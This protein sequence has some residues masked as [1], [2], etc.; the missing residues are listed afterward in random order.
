MADI[1][2]SAAPIAA[3]ADESAIRHRLAGRMPR[4]EPVPV[5]S[6][7]SSLPKWLRRARAAASTADSRNAVAAEWLLDNDYHVQRAILQI[8]EDLPPSFYQRLPGIAGEQARGAPRVY[9]LAHAL[10]RASHLQIALGSAVE[11]I[12]HYQDEEPL[13]IAELWA[14]PTMLR[15]ACLE[16]LIAGFARLFKDVPPPFD[17]H[18]EGQLSAGADDTECV[19][20]AIAN[21]A[22]ISSIPWKMFFDR[23]SRV[24]AILRRDPAA[25]YARMDFD[26][27]DRY[28]HAVEQLA[29]H[30]G[31]AEWDVAERLLSQ[32]HTQGDLPT[33]HIGYWL[34]DAGRPAFEDALHARPLTFVSLG[35]WLARYP[36]ALYTAALILVG[37]AGFVLPAAYLLTVEAKLSS[38]LIGIALIT[39]PASVLSVTFVNWLVT[40]LVAPRVLP[41][42]DFERGIAADCRTAVVMPV[43]VGNVA[44]IAPVLQRI[45]SHRLANSDPSLRFVLL[46]DHA[47]ADAEAMPGDGAIERALVEGIDRLNRRYPGPDG[48][49]PFHLLHRPRLYNAA[50]G[51]WMG[52]ERK[53]GKL[54]Q[55]NALI[56]HGTSTPFSVTTGDTGRLAGLR[57]VVTADADTR[58][59][60]GVV[61]QMVAAL[62]HPLN[63]AHF[64]PSSGR[65][66]SGYTILQ[67]RVEIAPENSGRS[68]FTHFFGGDTAI[69]I[70][71]RAVSDVYQDIF[72]TGIFVGKGIYDVAAFE[73][74]LAGRIPENALLSH[75][76]FE[77]LHGR[78][79][80]ASDII[81]YEG[82]PAGYLDYS[83]RWH[84]W[85]R[86]DWQIVAWLFP[87]VP[88]ADGSRVRNRLT[89]F[90]RL[91]IFDNLR[92]SVV[93]PSLVALLIGGW[94]LLGGNP[95]VWTLLALA[96]PAAYLF[97]DLVTG[98][99]QGRRRGVLQGVLRRL[100][101]HAGRWA[102]AITFL[103]SDSAIA[104]SAIVTTVTRLATR[105]RLLE[106]T[107]AAQM[108]AHVATLHPRWA[109]WRAML[110]SPLF[111]IAVAVALA[112]IEPKVL[113]IAGPILLLWLLAPEIAIWITRP[114][115]RSVE[116][117]DDEDRL[118]LRRL[119][120]RTWL[121]FET[122]VRP[123][124]NWLPPDNYQAPP[125][126]AT[127]HRTSPTNVGMMMLSTLT[128]WKLGHI[129]ANE[130]AVRLRNVLDTLDRL[131]RYRGHML[132]WY[133]TRTGQALE[134]R[135]VSA[136]DSGNLA[137]SLV[138]AKSACRE[139]ARAPILSLQRWD[140]LVDVLDLLAE[141]LGVEGI[142]GDGACRKLVAAMRESATTAPGQPAAW[143]QRL[144]TL[145][146]RDCGQLQDQVHHIIAMG[147][148]L[149]TEALHEVQVWVERAD[150]HLRAMQRDVDTLLPWQPFLEAP[151][152]GCFEIADELRP[153]LVDALSA[154]SEATALRA[155][156]TIAAFEQ[157]QGEGDTRDWARELGAALDLG[158]AAS[159]AL[160][161]DLERLASDAARQA[162]AMDFA[163]LFDSTT[164]L[165]NIGY[166]VSADRIDPHHYDLLASEARLASFFAIS[167]GD[168]PAEHW[169]SLGRPITKQA[170]G[171]ALV[172]WNGSMFEY[173]MPNLF[174]RSDPETL[175]GQ[176]D[177][178]AV[179]LQRDY[180]AA[181]NIP[182][183]ISESSFASMGAD[184]VY[185]YHAF[186]VPALGLRRGL[187]RDL[188]VAPYATA[189]ALAARPGLAIRNM[190][191]LAALGLIGRYGFYEAV[192]F[193]PERVPAGDRFAIVRSYMAHHQGMALAAMGN[194]LCGDMFVD[195]FHADPHIRT[196]DLLLNERI[197][198]ELP[199]EISR[200][201]TREAAPVPEGAIPPLHSW[202]AES[203]GRT[204]AVHVIGNGRMASR[205]TEG[206]S[207]SLHWH[208][209][210]LTRSDA[211]PSGSGISIYLRER[212]S[213]ALWSA[214]PEPIRSGATDVH[215]RFHGHQVEYHRRDHG[216][217]T[218]MTVSIPHGDDVEIRRIMVVNETD[219][220]RTIDFTSYAEVVL[221]P[222]ADAARHPA[223]SKLFVGS[224]MLPA[225]DG[226]LFSRRARDPKESTPVLLH[227]AIADEPGL[228]VRGVETDR[229]AFLG[230]HGHE[231]APAAL[232]GDTLPGGLGWTLDPVI[233]LQAEIEIPPFGR[234]EIAFLTI[235]A[236]SRETV[237][238]IAERY[239]TIPSMDWAVSDAATAVAR[240]MH[241]LGLAPHRVP[242]AQKLLS[243]LLQPVSPRATYEG[244]GSG[245]A[246][247]Q[248][249]WAL[250]ISGDHPILLLGAGDAER[251]GL[252]RFLLSAHQLWRHRGVAVDLVV[253]HEGAEGYLE[254]VRERLLAVLRDAGVQ[255]QLGQN[256]G[257]H[258]VGIERA[259]GDR[260]RL[261]GRSA[262]LR[263]DERGGSIADQ[264]S[265]LDAEPLSGPRFTPVVPDGPVEVPAP[266]ASPPRESL[267]FDNGLG[268]FTDG[269]R[270]Y[271]VAL[272][273]GVQTPAPWSN[274]LAN[275]GFGTIVTEAGLGFSWATNSGENRI[276]PWH[277]DPVKDPQGEILYVRDEENARVWTTTPQPAGGDSAARVRH[278]AGYTIWERESEGLAQE[279][280][281]AV[282]NDDP[283]KL[284]RLCLRNL[285]PRTRRITA[286]YYAEWLLGAVRGES[287][288]LRAADYDAGAHVLLATN[289]WNEE[290]Q[291]RT[292]FLTSTVPPH[293]LTTSRSDFLGRDGDVRRPQGLDKWDLGGRQQAAGGDCCAALQV[294]LDI[295]PGE[296]AEVCF[297]LGQ[298][299][300]RA[301]A[302]ALAQSWQDPAAID[303]GM[304]QVRDAWETRLGAVCVTTPDPAFDIMVNRWLPY[305]VTSARVRARAGFY[306]AGGAFGYRDQLQDVLALLHSDP[307]A[308][309]AQILAAAAHQ[310]EEGDVLHWWHPPFDRGVRTRCSDDMLWLT[311]ATATYVEATGDRAILDEE[312][313]FLRGP[314]LSEGESDRYA[315]FDVTD[316]PV[317]LFEHCERALDR[318][319]RL[320]AHGLPLMGAGDWNDGMNRVG[321]H[322]RGESVWLGWFLITAIDG[323]VRLCGGRGRTDLADR[324]TQRAR[325]LGEAVERSGWDGDWYLRA[326]DDDGRP[327]GSHNDEECRIDAI[328]QSWAVLSGAGDKARATRAVAAAR[329]ELV[330]DD[331]SIVRLLT[332]PFDRTPR[333]PGYIKAYPPG[334]RENGGQYTHAAAWLG[335]ATARLGDG[336][337]SMALFERINPINHGRSPAE[338]AQYRTEPYVLAGDVAGSAPH[339]GRGGW[340]WYTGAAGWVWRW[341]VE[342]ILG[343]RLVEGGIAI[344]CCLPPTWPH[345]EARITRASGSLQI[346]VDNPAGLATGVG[347]IKVDGAP[348]DQPIIPFPEDG[349]TRIVHVE[350]VPPAGT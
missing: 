289:P 201:E 35:R 12:E 211:S 40:L 159:A 266:G 247:R 209:H 4:A 232:N 244:V 149:P 262:H 226:L 227:R 16:L 290:F 36:A 151:P 246:S 123:E 145:L 72:G 292:A 65:V 199:P 325:R 178:S 126:E 315:R 297:V 64:D 174:L 285:L 181:R 245:R 214:G 251:S 57:F 97:T 120:R 1:E 11:F 160:R 194:A 312:L 300:D 249:L 163:L 286:T 302:V 58:L 18:P 309:R 147:D 2:R 196:I 114:I 340:S 139:A 21:L 223:F 200:I 124:D 313:P 116:T 14:F 222:P 280:T 274:V 154:G 49:G 270:E 195:W 63:I 45:E 113:L 44:D 106:W 108:S 138:V 140:G 304:M 85:V 100:S 190:R 210:A 180:G 112:L 169:F 82:F 338:T 94:F 15:L 103:V 221:A 250:G 7:I 55:F 277:N 216:I 272:A 153:M 13:S 99:A 118:F 350:L 337:G 218:S 206:G 117:L 187:S 68:L 158:A 24:E 219:R 19:S 241:T 96:A 258:L 52:W 257:V 317:S 269:G 318:G 23:V 62:A 78:A 256:G 261:L 334:I 43:I 271:V 172:S 73:R 332:P 215:T 10:L 41:K 77:G 242:E 240:E 236:G 148:M 121:F 203:S 279:L 87:I 89:W 263:L 26:T 220:T 127:A 142:D 119:A 305:Q 166:N 183:G 198:W 176:S 69:D 336:Q 328:A 17:I 343:L 295:A 345:F 30:S 252:L 341:A 122:F 314:Q 179:D 150:H 320:G 324:W 104:L 233:G 189:L 213:G 102:L 141:A 27:R 283:V 20:R 152:E 170:H 294:H 47:D 264:L 50:Q 143:H 146:E 188:V 105:R 217:A 136:V 260:A 31:L 243:R 281:V 310:F 88:G 164:K 207:G 165:F 5:W 75:D 56:L 239:T 230:R 144:G 79:G 34:V 71:S 107:A 197:P 29:A 101:D 234:R 331:D 347:R 74:S 46:S 293:S 192:D 38:W 32:C 70:Y 186:G 167:K 193:T 237:Q 235:A 111:A 83:R 60:P 202:P 25:V 273:P 161:D 42:L 95:L 288:P 131:E 132:N 204:I 275:S 322:D 86:G 259:D 238:E 115:A 205:L 329:R 228:R 53:R 182:W 333:D 92:R 175:L 37:I 129:G 156:A 66:S 276:T 98:L 155:R 229:L 319:Y 134:P 76:L 191:E 254:P 91:K 327:W 67:P 330:C 137:V 321:E 307:G 81:V 177:R 296:T 128:A 3:S 54:A 323:F 212:A 61:N 349:S 133:D 265:R 39:T 48:K 255:D 162:E 298:G 84:R 344:S 346:R 303:R 225:M 8:G 335:I 291:D 278:G 267:A 185:G 348:W 301:H 208:R 311:Y 284:V 282:P 51:C 59:P 110:V 9:M 80:L 184:R 28:R 168:V 308:A 90:D 342:E 224:E 22:V 316:H 135:Y 326:F 171:L 6:E 268:G 339:V 173:L 287:A 93:P 253:M 299:T 125:D 248:D 306:Q 231:S 130:V 157:K 109:A 33:G